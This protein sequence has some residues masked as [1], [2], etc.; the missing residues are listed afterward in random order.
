MLSHVP[1]RLLTTIV[2]MSEVSRGEL[3]EDKVF[4]ENTHRMNYRIK[5]KKNDDHVLHC[6][7]LFKVEELVIVRLSVFQ[8]NYLPLT[9]QHTLTLNTFVSLN[10]RSII[11]TR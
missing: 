9:H 8:Y 5:E 3:H 6:V 7:S 1:P 4:G 10:R 11:N 2:E